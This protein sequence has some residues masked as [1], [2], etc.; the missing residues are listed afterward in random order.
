MKKFWLVLSISMVGFLSFVLVSCH[1]KQEAANSI[2]VGTIAGPETQLME[3]AKDVAAKKY[4][5][6]VNVITFSDYNTPN[7][8]LN[9]GDIDAN[10][11][12]NIPFLQSQIQDRGYKIVSVAKTFVYP[13][14]LYSKKISKLSDL[15]PGSKVG[16]P[17]DPS[18]ESRALLLLEKAKLIQL[19][20]GAGVNA[21]LV[22]ITANPKNI[23][24]VELDAAEL[25]RAL[26]DLSLAAINT[27]FA[28]PEGL[29]PAA[30]ALFSESAESP[31]TNIIVVRAGEQNNPKILELI[32]SFQS[33]EVID[34]AKQLFGDAAI[35]G[36][37]N[38]DTS[39]NPKSKH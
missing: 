25:P 30:D 11:F 31:Y 3:V 23:K 8:A 22:D 13:M 38:S 14:G 6:N 2:S 29:S 27:N 10:A 12:Q 1:Q 19:R 26:K 7:E 39:T 17:N 21:T 4:G 24:F 18:N 15:Q 16:V 9:D 5:L 37:V 20:P 34:E 32:K 33:Q 28:I 36:W 35:P